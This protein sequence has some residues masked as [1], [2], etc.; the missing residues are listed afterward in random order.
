MNRAANSTSRST[1][2]RKA[3]RSRRLNAAKARWTSSTFASDIRLLPQLHGFEGFGAVAVRLEAHEQPVANC[4]LVCGA[5]LG[6]STASLS[7]CGHPN[8]HEY[9]LVVDV[10]E[11]LRLE[12]NR[13]APGSCVDEAPDSVSAPEHRSVRVSAVRSNSTSGPVRSA[14]V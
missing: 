14:N 13:S 4:E 5:S 7:D 6:G 3:S 11:A 1:S 10:E 8:E 12:L 2:A 9:A